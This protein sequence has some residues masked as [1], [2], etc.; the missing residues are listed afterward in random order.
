[1]PNPEYADGFRFGRWHSRV[2][3]TPE[4]LGQVPVSCMAEE[5]ATPG[6]GRLRALI[7][8]A[9]NPAL[10][11]PG[12]DHVDEALPQLDFMVSIDNW[13]NETTRHAD[14]ILPG[15]SNMEQPHYDE[16]IWS[17][18]VR[19]CGKYTPALFDPGER[20]HEWEILLT[21][22]AICQGA[23][24]AEVDA[25]ALDQLFFAGLV[26]GL[27][28]MPG[29]RIEGRDP[30]EIVA[31]TEGIGPERILD[32]QIRTGP[33]GDAYGADPEGLTLAELQRHPDG[34]D[35]GALTP[36]LDE[37]LA[38]PSGK[39]ELA[40]PYITDDL[41]R[42]RERLS[43]REPEF[44]LV[45]RRHVRSNNSWMHNVPRLV[46]GRNRCTLLIHPDDAARLGV[47]DGKLA[48]VTSEAG[49]LVVETAVSDEM[50]PGVVC[51]PH[52]WGHDKDGA[53]LGV[54]SQHAGVCNN[55]LAPGHFVDVPSGN[56]AVNGIPVELAPA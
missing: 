17:W 53:R 27:T 2:R 50:M 45:S 42:L 22:A 19:N 24:P 48:R 10:S 32:F 28:Q 9:G 21:L 54:A 43:R 12:A 6:E 55:V 14:V 52:G 51:L 41:P 18:A 56:A 26:A 13:V 23:N 44:V 36:R 35:K 15:L 38:T 7:T 20:P 29:T 31:A 47:E 16:L 25:R 1:L 34:I 33:W 49:V 8:I 40:P 4:V 11:S 37:V 39:I 3:G 46:S 5:I 30:A